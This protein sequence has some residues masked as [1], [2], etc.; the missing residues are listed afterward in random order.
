M[1][2]PLPAKEFPDWAPKLVVQFHYK[3]CL[4]NEPALYFVNPPDNLKANWCPSSRLSLELLEMATLADRWC[5]HDKMESVWQKIRAKVGNDEFE[6]AAYYLTT[7]AITYLA[8]FREVMKKTHKQR[9]RAYQRIQSAALELMAAI[10]DDP[11]FRFIHPF[12]LLS[13]TELEKLVHNA[14]HIA[15]FSGDSAGTIKIN[16]ERA[17]QYAKSYRKIGDVV[18]LSVLTFSELLERLH[19]DA[20]RIMTEDDNT[21]HTTGR[22]AEINFFLKHMTV[23][24]REKFDEFMDE[25]LATFANVAFNLDSVTDHQVAQTRARSP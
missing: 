16:Q 10:D 4:Y 21:Q 5:S 1:T 25:T 20:V 11:H 3:E 7:Q 13:P 19:H 6:G 18:G 23:E 17:D 12:T 22:Q 8:F 15:G 14:S 9:Q 24:F 2:T